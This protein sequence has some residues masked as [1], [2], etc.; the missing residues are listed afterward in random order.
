MWLQ[1]AMKQ[2]DCHRILFFI[3]TIVTSTVLIMVIS[4]SSH[5]QTFSDIFGN[6]WSFP[7]TF[8]HFYPS[9]VILGHLQPFPAIFVI[10]AISSLFQQFL[11]RYF[12]LAISNHFHLFPDI[13]KI[14]LTIFSY[15]QQCHALY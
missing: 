5:F 13:P 9:Q 1:T 11:A 14:N 12:F 8:S 7:V 10:F 2:C 15:F 4:I 6:F 3:I